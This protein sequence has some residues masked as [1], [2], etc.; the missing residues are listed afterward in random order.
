MSLPNSLTLITS[1]FATAWT[2]TPI[3]WPNVSFD[4]KSN[5]EFVRFNV[6]FTKEDRRTLGLSSNLYRQYGLVSMHIFTPLNRGAKR[7]LEL[8]EQLTAIWRSASI[9]GHIFD[10][11]NTVVIGNVDGVYQVNVNISFYTD[12]FY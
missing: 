9:Q 4:M 2:A 1:T 7:A 10:T 12:N 8:A 3:A 6:L 11:P 5:P